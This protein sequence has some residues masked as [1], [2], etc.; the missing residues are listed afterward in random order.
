VSGDPD[1]SRLPME[2][3]DIAARLTLDFLAGD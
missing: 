1:R 3:P 2:K